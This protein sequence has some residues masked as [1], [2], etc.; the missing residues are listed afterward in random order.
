MDRH[1]DIFLHLIVLGAHILHIELLNTKRR[2]LLR[3]SAETGI[4]IY[5]AFIL[6]FLQPSRRRLN[7]C[8]TFGEDPGRLGYAADGL[9]SARGDAG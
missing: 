4:G 7:G 1:A 3:R 2:G 8:D 6:Q 5:D 9:D